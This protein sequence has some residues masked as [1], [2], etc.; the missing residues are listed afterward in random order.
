LFGPGGFSFGK[1]LKTSGF[2]VIITQGKAPLVFQ[3][4]LPPWGNLQLARNLGEQPL[5]GNKSTRF[6]PT[7]F[8]QVVL[9]PGKKP[10][11]DW[12]W[13]SAKVSKKLV[14]N[15]GVDIAKGGSLDLLENSE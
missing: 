15:G 1:L 14:G 6:F 10:T 13:G 12:G 11:E 2:Q 4:Q 8:S 9:G 3:G 7:E 5:Q